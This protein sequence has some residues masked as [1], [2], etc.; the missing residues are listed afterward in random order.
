[1]ANFSRGRLAAK[2]SPHAAAMRRVWIGWCS[3]LRCA[4]QET[5][6]SLRSRMA[7]VRSSV[8][9]FRFLQAKP[10]TIHR[11]P[12]REVPRRGG[13]SRYPRAGCD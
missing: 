12:A 13:P 6:C 8:A 9:R 3:D 5:P 10:A 4:S 11:A 2:S 7:G 1:L